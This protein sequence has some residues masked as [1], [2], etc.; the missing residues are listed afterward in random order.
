MCIQPEPD[1]R[2]LHSIHNITG[3]YKEELRSGK[4]STIFEQ[5]E[6]W[7]EPQLNLRFVAQY[8]FKNSR[9]RSGWCWR[10]Q[11]S[12]HEKIV[13]C[14]REPERRHGSTI[15]PGYAFLAWRSSWRMIVYFYFMTSAWNSIRPQLG[16]FCQDNRYGTEKAC[17]TA[18]P[19]HTKSITPTG[20]LS[21]S[22]SGGPPC[23]AS[24]LAFGLI[25]GNRHTNPIITLQ[26]CPPP[27][28]RM[29]WIGKIGK[30]IKSSY[31]DLCVHLYN[32]KKQPCIHVY[33]YSRAHFH[34]RIWPWEVWNKLPTAALHASTPASLVWGLQLAFFIRNT[35]KQK[36]DRKR[37]FCKLI[38]C[39]NVQYR[40]GLQ[41]Q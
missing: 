41:G 4:P 17:G 38:L 32:H 37:L 7:T 12:R 8:F 10:D 22:Q 19:S 20:S 40:R 16:I 11:S 26:N 33:Y 34:L 21:S 23:W 30:I 2:L 28:Q 36:G 31:T 6:P 9:P 29:R 18:R 1:L 13:R 24:P 25:G 39:K 15:V 5:Y 3:T 35:T 27:P 14:L